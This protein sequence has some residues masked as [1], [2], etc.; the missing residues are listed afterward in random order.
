[1]FLAK[2]PLEKSSRCEAADTTDPSSADNLGIRER[3]EHFPK[4][5]AK[6]FLRCDSERMRFG[7]PSES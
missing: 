6:R 4:K 5:P 3:E 1:M 7:V 2:S